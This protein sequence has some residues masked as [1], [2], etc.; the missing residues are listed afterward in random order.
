MTARLLRALGASLLLA[1][2]VVV[3]GGTPA[4]AAACG[5]GQGVTVVVDPQQLGGGDSVACAA[6]VGGQSASSIFGEAG[7][8]LT[9]V[10]TEP[11]AVCRVNGAPSNANCGRMPPANRYWSLWWSKG[12]GTWTYANLGVDGLKVPQGGWVAWSWQGQNAKA[13]P[14]ITPR[15]ASGS[16]GSSAGS[17]STPGGGSSSG[18][19]SS[20]GTSGTPSPSSPAEKK[21]AQKQKAEKQRKK[22]LEKAKRKADEKAGRTQSASAATSGSQESDEA[23]RNASQEGAGPGSGAWI[24]ILAVLALGGTAGLTAWRRHRTP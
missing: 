6:G 20:R 22:Q 12:D 14:S 19:S 24:A 7:V 4:S 1:T 10:T 13:A 23:V 5:A 21:A 11:G 9:R 16:G 3:G 8:G 2:S 15:N 18:S 17:P